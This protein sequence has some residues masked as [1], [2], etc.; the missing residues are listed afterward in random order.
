MQNTLFLRRAIFCGAILLL[1][2][3]TAVTLMIIGRAREA[4]V[5]AAEDSVERISLATETSINRAFVQVDATLA[6]LPAILSYFAQN[7][8]LDIPVVNR[9]L[10]QLINQNFTYRDVLLLG[11]NGLP[12]ASALPV[13]RDRKSTRLNSSHT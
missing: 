6:G 2:A 5:R 11:P 8:H 3:Q 1:L 9:V 4:Q 7:G 10:R 12:V 13:S